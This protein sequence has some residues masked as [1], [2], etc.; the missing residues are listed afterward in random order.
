[1]RNLRK[2][3]NNGLEVKKASGKIQSN[4]QKKKIPQLTMGENPFGYKKTGL[5]KIRRQK[6]SSLYKMHQ[7]TQ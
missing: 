7:S 6:N 4:H 3:I 1:M 5:Q 2:K